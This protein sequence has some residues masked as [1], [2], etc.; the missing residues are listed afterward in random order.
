MKDETVIMIEEHYSVRQID[1]KFKSQT[2]DL[3][4]H[5]GLLINP[6]TTQVTMTNGTV[7]WQTKLLYMGIGALILLVPW[8]SWVTTQL[9]DRGDQLTRDDVEQIIIERLDEY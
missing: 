6:L 2:A 4:E 3:K 9:L 8:A 1:E 7:K 5:M